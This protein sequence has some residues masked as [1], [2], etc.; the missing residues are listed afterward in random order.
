MSVDS[1][2]WISHPI[3]THP[4]GSVSLENPD[5]HMH[6]CSVASAMSNSLRPYGLEPTRLLCP[7][8]CPDQSTWVSCPFL[9][10]G[11]LP[12]PGIHPVSLAFLALGGGV[13]TTEPAGKFP[14]LT[15][16][17]ITRAKKGTRN[18]AFCFCFFLEYLLKELCLYGPFGLYGLYGSGKNR[19]VQDLLKVR[20]LLGVSQYK[21][22]PPKIYILDVNIH[23]K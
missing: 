10:P 14:L 20:C 23:K 21:A 18:P 19:H 17:M 6:A 4:I 8:D 22:G 3:H 12:N 9:L 16:Q 2:K 13:F 7:W 1:Q 15:S 5:Q 11:D